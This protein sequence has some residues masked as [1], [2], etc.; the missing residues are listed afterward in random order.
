MGDLVPTTAPSVCALCGVMRAVP[1]AGRRAGV[2]FVVVAVIAACSSPSH[3]HL[4]HAA[5]TTTTEMNSSSSTVTEA[6]G[7]STRAASSPFALSVVECPTTYG[8]GRPSYGPVLS[9]TI[10]VDLPRSTRAE[11]SYYSNDTRTLPPI[12]GPR[13]W[14]CSIEV[15]ADGSIGVNIYPGTSPSSSQS[16]LPAIQAASASACQGCVLTFVCGFVPD[17]AQQLGFTNSGIN[18]A[19]RPVGE[20]ISWIRGSPSETG[21]IRHVI[22]FSDPGN[23]S[24]TE[25]NG[26]ILYDYPT[27]QGGG[28]SSYETCTLPDNLHEICTAILN[29]FINRAWQ[30]TP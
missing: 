20:T 9:E 24:A 4:G 17:A 5:S 23:P 10:D 14:N 26:V 18:C 3:H 30:I 1:L 16:H 7:T 2:G 13:E 27:S 25:T 22:A 12:M 6:P 28:S 29:D 19:P 11:L 15:G 8:A 21:N